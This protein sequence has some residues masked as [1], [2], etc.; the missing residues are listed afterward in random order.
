MNEEQKLEALKE[1]CTVAL[2]AASEIWEDDAVALDKTIEI[3][4]R[5]RGRY[6]K[7]IKN[8]APK[9]MLYAD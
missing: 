5:L 3:F 7:E 2:C 4:W 8:P 1:A 9:G 6:R